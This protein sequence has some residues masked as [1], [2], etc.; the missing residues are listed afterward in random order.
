M[1]YN[2]KLKSKFKIENYKIYTNITLLLLLIMGSCLSTNIDSQISENKEKINNNSVEIEKDKYRSDIINNTTIVGQNIREE[3]SKCITDENAKLNAQL[4]ASNA[5]LNAQL[6]AYTARMEEL[7][8][9][10]NRLEND[11]NELKEY[12]KESNTR[13]ENNYKMIMKMLF[14]QNNIE[15]TDEEKDYYINQISK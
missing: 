5:E 4:T 2:D 3:L 9:S 7:S 8:F 15:L 14:K 13:L 10:N 12:N 11:V 1:E 6:T